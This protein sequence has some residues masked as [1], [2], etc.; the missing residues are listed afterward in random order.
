MNITENILIYGCASAFLF[1]LLIYCFHRAKKKR[2]VMSLKANVRSFLTEY[3]SLINNEYIIK[4]I[5]ESRIPNSLLA[6][7]GELLCIPA[8]INNEGKLSPVFPDHQIIEEVSKESACFDFADLDILFN[9]A[10]KKPSIYTAALAWLCVKENK[11]DLIKSFP[12]SK[13]MESYIALYNKIVYL[14]ESLLNYG[15]IANNNKRTFDAFLLA[16]WAC[17]EANVKYSDKH[18]MQIIDE[19][20]INEMEHEYLRSYQFISPETISRWQRQRIIDENDMVEMLYSF[21]DYEESTIIYHVANHIYLRDKIVLWSE[22]YVSASGI[23]R[24]AIDEIQKREYIENLL[25]GHS[26][27]RVTILDVDKMDPDRFELLIASLFNKM[28]YEAY[29]TKKSRDQGVDVIAHKRDR[30]IAIQAKCYHHSVGN[31]AIQEVVAGKFF[32]HADDAFVVTN[33]TFTKAA[34]QL[35][36]ANNVKLW[37]RKCLAE[38]LNRYNF[39][40]C[41]F[42]AV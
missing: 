4:A 24:T 12:D 31:S 18:L 34:I 30:K 29:P 38:N 2:R 9:N 17:A 7:S 27:P 16:I 36:S 19:D 41:D 40:E 39:C 22:A 33:S 15:T 13:S 26:S 6:C 32:Y 5:Q 21:N 1:F 42:C 35:A 25:N 11:E 14:F 23:V 28:G 3:I 10:I 37:D 20:V 8:A